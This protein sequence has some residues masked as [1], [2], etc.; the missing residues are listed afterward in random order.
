M[1]VGKW[2]VMWVG[3][4]PNYF[5]RGGKRPGRDQIFRK[6]NRA[7]SKKKFGE[8][9]IGRGEKKFREGGNRAG[10]KNFSELHPWS[11]MLKIAVGERVRDRGGTSPPFPP[12]AHVCYHSTN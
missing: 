10:R 9:G 11:G 12:R 5:W 7:G 1:W 6:G 8:G 3:N 4:W 2:G